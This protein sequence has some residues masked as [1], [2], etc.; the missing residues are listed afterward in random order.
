MSGVR[1]LVPQGK[2]VPQHVRGPSSVTQPHVL[3]ATVCSWSLLQKQLIM[4]ILSPT[5]RLAWRLPLQDK[6][7]VCLIME[8]VPGDNLH[9]R[10]YRGQAGGRMS[11]IDTLQ[12]GHVQCQRQVGQDL[13]FVGS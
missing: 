7:N 9:M 13:R 4:C 6:A 2:C 12:V 3:P 8:L 1:D 10:I 5:N 11:Y